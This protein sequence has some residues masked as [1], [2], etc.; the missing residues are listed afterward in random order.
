MSL[1]ANGKQAY[2]LALQTREQHIRRE[3]ATSNI[4]TAQALLANVAAAYGCWHGPDGLRAIAYSVHHLAQQL[5]GALTGAGLTV[6]SSA[7]FDTVTVQMPGAAAAA[8][9]RAVEAGINLRLVDA[10]RVGVSFDET[11]TVDT[12]ATVAGALV[13]DLGVATFSSMEGFIP[14]SVLTDRDG[15]WYRTT[16]FMTD[17]RFHRYQSEHEML[18]WLRKL[19]DR[20]LALDRTMIPLGSCTMKLNAAAEMEPIRWPEFAGIHPFAPADQTVGYRTLI[21]E[22]EEALIEVTGYDA[23]SLQPNAGSQGEYAGLL[24]IRAYHQSR[25]DDQRDVCLIPSSAHGT[26]AASAVLAGMRVVVVASTER[27]DVD[28]D[29]LNAKIDEHADTLA[30]LMVTYP[31]THG[32]YERT[33]IEIC[34][35]VHA[36]GGQVY[37]DG[38][39]LNALVGAAKPGRFG[40]DVS[41]LNL[42]KT[43]CI[44]HGG[45]GPGVGPGRRRQ[46][47]CT[48]P[49]G[50]QRGRRHRWRRCRRPSGRGRVGRTIRV[51]GHP[52]HHVD[53]HPDDGRRR[54]APRHRGCRAR[55]EL[56]REA[57]QRALPGALHRAERAR[58]PRVHHRPAS[59]HRRHRRHRRRRRQAAR[60]LWLP[61]PHHVV[62]GRR[63]PDDRANRVGELG[64]TRPVLRRHD[65]HQG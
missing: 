12:L 9:H 23:I 14:V 6:E 18:R 50:A 5:A 1:D 34:D 4:C 45:G 48:V 41:H 58:R 24:A 46:P 64:R 44:P 59:H 47:S 43:F 19:A 35:R 7:F 28:L 31:S 60:R 11:S 20:D 8:V 52:A 17:E 42:H 65:H 16:G 21:R 33:I 55:C 61:C 2:R 30:A 38:A 54:P 15:P 27:G 29:D 51:G 53:V 3:K 37:T 13:P 63:H 56:R 26:N 62:P 36:A 10:D 57:T 49:P 40:S 32:V 22:V 25:G 39:N